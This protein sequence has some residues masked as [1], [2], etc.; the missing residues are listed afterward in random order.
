SPRAEP[1]FP[2]S[3]FALAPDSLASFQIT[4]PGIPAGIT[5]YQAASLEVIPHGAADT[6]R[7]TTP[8]APCGDHI[9]VRPIVRGVPPV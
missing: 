4:Y 1:G 9:N 7:I 6:L 5:C 3:T 2:D 8:I